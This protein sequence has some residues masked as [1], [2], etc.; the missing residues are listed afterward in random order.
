ME[1]ARSVSGTS[2]GGE[3]VPGIGEEAIFTTAHRMFF[4]REGTSYILIQPQFVRD[5]RGVAIAAAKK[6]LESVL[7]R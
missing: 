4:V 7:S 5:P 2:L 6:V 3:A 1:A